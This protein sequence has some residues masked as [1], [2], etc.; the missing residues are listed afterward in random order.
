ME[1]AHLQQ[2]LIDPAL[3]IRCNSCEESCPV[4][5]ISHARN[6]VVDHSI[7]SGCAVRACIDPC[8]T[9]AINA[10]RVIEP[11]QV[12]GLAAQESWETLPPQAAE[13]AVHL[14]PVTPPAP[15]P[16]DPPRIVQRPPASAAI[17]VTQK[18]T[19]AQP[20]TAVVLESTVL[21]QPVQGGEVRHLVLGFAAADFPVLEGQ[22]LSVLPPGFDPQGRGHPPRTY[23]IAS[24]RD[25]E[26]GKPDT[27]SLTVKRVLGEATGDAFK[28]LGSN[29]LCDL[30]VGERLHV[31]GPYGATFLMPESADARLVMIC[32]GTGVA[33]MRAMIQRRIRLGLGRDRLHLFCGART[34]AEL[35]YR[36]EIANQ[37][38]EGFVDVHLAYSREADVE[39]Q[40]V[41]DK[42]LEQVMNLSMWLAE[43]DSH[44]YL[45][46]LRGMESGVFEAFELASSFVGETWARLKLALHEQGRLHIETY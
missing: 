11:A 41:Q 3:C 45:C 31:A 16:G 18:Y 40:Y 23:S 37:W 28:G 38:P 20:T 17:P 7:C 29:Y 42:L 9:G 19:P 39:K 21:T 5:A 14:R 46:G 8:P 36:A 12:Y 13:L 10:W 27:V 22:S 35:P 33:P 26:Q 6:Y 34:A 25:G 2:H 24:E 43:P 32:T 4:D 44:F 30:K 1:P 15:K